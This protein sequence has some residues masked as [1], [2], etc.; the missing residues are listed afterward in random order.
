MSFAFKYKSGQEPPMVIYISHEEKTPSG[1]WRPSALIGFTP[2][3]RTSGFL[4]SI[5][6]DEFRSLLLLLSF[7]APDGRLFA[8]TLQLAKAL[9]L[10]RA[11]AH[12][13]FE[14]LTKARWLGQQMVCATF[15]G[16]GLDGFTLVPGFIPFVE[17]P[18]EGPMPPVLRVVPRE[19]IIEHSRRRYAK[20]RKEVEREIAEMM[21]WHEKP[22]AGYVTS[23][24][25]LSP[26]Q[27]ELK[28]ELMEVGL[29]DDQADE[30]MKRFDPIRIRRQLAWLPYRMAKN[31]TGYLIAAIK[32]DYAAPRNSKV[33]P[34]EQD[35]E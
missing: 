4:L 2:A 22:K 17:E 19:V 13:C 23:V 1:N 32:D 20:T 5:E 25:V 26:E 11:K 21:N 10:S 8:S 28:A 34:N 14:K 9:R 27:H 31:R 7:I 24:E 33:I 6:P 18:V 35:D 15:V 16:N 12:A 30:L 3:L 29:L